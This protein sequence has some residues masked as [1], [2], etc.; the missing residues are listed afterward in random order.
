MELLG[1]ELTIEQ[2]IGFVRCNATPDEDLIHRAELELVAELEASKRR[3]RAAVEERDT[4]MR[5]HSKQVEVIRQ[6]IDAGEL[7]AEEKRLLDDLVFETQYD[8]RGPA[9][10]A[11][12]TRGTC[13]TTGHPCC[14]CAPVC[15]DERRE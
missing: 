12:P 14:G 10:E 9:Q 7:I 13:T 6:R 11:E 4:L 1:R 15:G 3:E 2:V 8:R 5:R